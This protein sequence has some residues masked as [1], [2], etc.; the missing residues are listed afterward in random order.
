MVVQTPEHNTCIVLIYLLA[1]HCN[2][3]LVYVSAYMPQFSCMCVARSHDMRI[4][5]N[6]LFVTPCVYRMH[7]YGLLC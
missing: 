2:L 7:G 4:I 6:A 5:T 1:D 3:E